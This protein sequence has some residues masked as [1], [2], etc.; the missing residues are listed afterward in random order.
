[1]PTILGL[2]GVAPPPGLPGRDLS[3][4]AEGGAPPADLWAFSEVS[5]AHG[6]PIYLVRIGDIAMMNERD[7]M[8]PPLVFDLRL[9]PGEQRAHEGTADKARLFQKYVGR[10]VGP[11]PSAAAT[12][13][14]DA[15]TIAQ[16]KALGY[17]DQ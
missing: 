3:A 13:E 10:A 16:L 7:T 17:L 1:M 14:L 6:D 12:T 5:H 2:A 11:P 15:G 4:V 9:D 8:S